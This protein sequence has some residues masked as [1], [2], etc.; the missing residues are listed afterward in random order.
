MVGDELII[1]GLS[2]GGYTIVQNSGQNI[3]AS[4]RITTTGVGGSLSTTNQYDAITLRC[5]SANLTWGTPAGLQGI[6]TIV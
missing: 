6:F 3:I 4:N 2:A 5:M 1:M